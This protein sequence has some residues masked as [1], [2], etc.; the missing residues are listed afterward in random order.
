MQ[1]DPNHESRK[2]SKLLGWIGKL[3]CPFKGTVCGNL[4]MLICKSKGGRQVTKGLRN[5][6]MVLQTIGG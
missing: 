4:A 6:D 1:H 3:S 2:A 5:L